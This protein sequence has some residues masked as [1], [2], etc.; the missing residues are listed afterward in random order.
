M[1]LQSAHLAFLFMFVWQ[2]VMAEDDLLGPTLTTVITVMLSGPI[3]FCTQ[4]FF[5]FRLYIFSHKKALPVFCSFMVIAQL[6]ITL[7]FGFFMGIT[8][9]AFIIATDLTFTEKFITPTLFITICVDTTIAVS[10]SYYLKASES[11]LRRTSRVVDRMV[12]YIMATGTITSIF[13]LASGV[14]VC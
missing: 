13:A 14:A 11:G 7:V 3:A 6:A 12:F 8:E 2:L 10:M 1:Y 5:V 4:A 9:P